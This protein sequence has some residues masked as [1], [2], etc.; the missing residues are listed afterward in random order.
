M[1]TK[2]LIQRIAEMNDQLCNFKEGLNN[3]LN[4]Y[5]INDSVFIY[6]DG[7]VHT[8]NNGYLIIKEEFDN[9]DEA[10]K[11]CDIN[12][13]VIRITENKKFEIGEIYNKLAD[14]PEDGKRLIIN[15]V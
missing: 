10:I 15:P 8:V 11:H 1:Y 9:I 6:K 12:K 5:M 7:Q 4:K 14:C 13:N 2:S 3:L